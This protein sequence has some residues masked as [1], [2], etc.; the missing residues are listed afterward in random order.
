MLSPVTA[1]SGATKA[2]L[3]AQLLDARRAMSTAQRDHAASRITRFLLELID[4]RAPRCLA[5]YYSFGTEPSTAELLGAL[6]SHG[7]RVLLPVLRADRDLDWAIYDGPDRGAPGRLGLWTPDGP[8]LGVAAV[9]EADLVVAPA[10]AV[11]ANGV[12][13]GRGGG[14]YDQALARVP[15]DRLVLALLY[16]GELL[17]DVPADPHDRSV[18]AA[19][20]PSGVHWFPAA[21]GRP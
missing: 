2:R 17:P 21:R 15:A 20:T 12:R 5:A 10:L 6:R 4:V 14:S 8:G 13:L 9:A 11:G 3:R 18:D 1:T 19:V 7:V 16:D